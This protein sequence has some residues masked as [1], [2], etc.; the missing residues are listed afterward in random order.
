[1]PVAPNSLLQAAPA[2]KPQAPVA[3]PSGAAA[4]PR[5]KGPGFAQVFA[6]QGSKPTVKADDNSPKPARDKPADAS[7]MDRLVEKLSACVKT[8]DCVPDDA[9]LKEQFEAGKLN[10]LVGK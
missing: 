10:D 6:S 2:A 4:D 9:A 5:D 8:G 3:T 1:M 7:A